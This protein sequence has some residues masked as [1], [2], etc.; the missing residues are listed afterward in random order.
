MSSSLTEKRGILALIGSAAAV[1]WTGSLCFG[2]QGVMGPYWKTM[3]QVGR[4]AIGNNLFF[5][6]A[7]LGLCMYFVGKWQERYGVR[8][9]IIIGNLILALNMLISAFASTLAMIYLWSFFNGLASC[10]IYTPALTCVQ[11]W[12]PTRRGLAS[13][14]VNFTFGISAAVTPPLFHSMLE[15]MG[16]VKMNLAVA[17]AALLTG[18]LAS[19]FT[20]DPDKPVVPPAASTS[21]AATPSLPL[22]QSLTALESVR[23]KSFWFLWVTWCLQGAATIA[24]ISLST[25]FG[26][27]RGFT[28]SSAVIILTAF[29]IANG[30]GRI[31]MG[32]A[33]DMMN[34]NQ[35]MSVV[36][37]ASGCA[38]LLLPHV[39]GLLATTVLAAIVGLAFGTLFSV[40][41][42]L[43]VDCFGI[44][45]FGSIFGLIFTACFVAGLLGPSLSGYVLDVTGGN[46]TIVFTYLGAFCLLSSALIHFVVP[47]H[48][49]WTQ[50]G[51]REG[52]GIET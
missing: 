39:T 11:R 12:F 22:G 19:S 49:P 46:F 7:P 1:F 45:H 25:T 51:A 18:V 21:T 40:S 42:P 37:L 41:A 17:A 8:R 33:S 44:D 20:C 43:A 50:V 5:Q 35:S 10:F 30:G 28:M 16:Y 32:Y 27:S 47:Q 36:F 34:R 38:Y 23:T 26:L 14:V 24:M 13:G 2:F 31:L 29:H 3:F 52:F 48:A 4:G 6:L 15:S 9:M